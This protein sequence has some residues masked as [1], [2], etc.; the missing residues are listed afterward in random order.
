VFVFG[1]LIPIFIA[2]ILPQRL[3]ATKFFGFGICS[4]ILVSDKT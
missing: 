4:E 1:K 3:K 2:I